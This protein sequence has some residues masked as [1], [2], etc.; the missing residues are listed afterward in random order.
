MLQKDKII[1]KINNINNRY[2]THISYNNF[3]INLIIKVKNLI[4]ISG[5]KIFKS[6]K[7]FKNSDFLN[8]CLL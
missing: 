3:M 8:I 1:Q 5:K 6:Y 4:K 2:S 7:I